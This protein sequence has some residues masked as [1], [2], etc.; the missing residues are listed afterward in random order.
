MLIKKAVLEEFE[1]LYAQGV[2]RKDGK[3]IKYLGG[4][5]AQGQGFAV[6]A[7]NFEKK[8]ILWDGEN[9]G[10]T[11]TICQINDN[12]DFYANERF[13]PIFH[14][15][16]CVLVYGELKEEGYEI[17]EVQKIP[18][19]HRFDVVKVGDD[20]VFVGASLSRFKES[21]DDWSNPG[22]IIIGKLNK[23]PKQPMELKVINDEITKNHGYCTTTYNGKRVILIT[24]V[25]GMYC[26]YIPERFEDEWKIEKLTDRETSDACTVDIDNDGIDEIVTIE[27]FHGNELIVNKLVGGEWKKIFEKEIAFGH[28]LWGGKFLGKNRFFAGW[29]QGTKE[30]ICFEQDADTIKET[31]IGA[32]GTSQFSVWEENNIGYILSADRQAIEQTGQLVLYTITE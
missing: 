27:K 11:M 22:E 1:K 28:G 32:G 29:R 9:S 15:P 18:W 19:L 4:A 31:V 25:E 7:D 13:F 24:G 17:T 26:V 20:S 12:G 14:G 23:D 6:D 5:E 8:Q 16:D 10:G 30:L 2:I 21:K 3:P